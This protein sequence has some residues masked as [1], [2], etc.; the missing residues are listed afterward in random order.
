MPRHA[1]GEGV[2]GRDFPWSAEGLPVP[3]KRGIDIH[4]FSFRLTY[5]APVYP[6]KIPA[7]STKMP[8]HTCE[9]RVMFPYSS[10]FRRPSSERFPIL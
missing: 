6:I 3:G 2:D 5:P 7:F 4:L 8:T 1:E 10:S 9:K